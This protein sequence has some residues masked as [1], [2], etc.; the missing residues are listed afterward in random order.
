M[1]PGFEQ[2]TGD[3]FGS[4][5]RDWRP[6]FTTTAPSHC[7]A[8]C[9]FLL[10]HQR[11]TFSVFSVL[12]DDPGDVNYG[13]GYTYFDPPSV[14]LATIRDLDQQMVERLRS[15]SMVQDFLNGRSQSGSSEMIY[16]TGT[17]LLS[18]PMF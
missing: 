1:D 15:E 17:S 14:Y 7:L 2:V 13:L 4:D 9:S 12:M 3:A 5:Q 8:H 16:A 10:A 11:S 18:T 6:G